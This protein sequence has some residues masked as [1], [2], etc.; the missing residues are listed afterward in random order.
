MRDFDKTH[1]V[2]LQQNNH[3]NYVDCLTMAALDILEVKTGDILNTYM[4]APNRETYELYQVQ[5]VGTML[6]SQ[7]YMSD[8]FVV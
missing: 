7:P 4:T 6:I 1:Q 8:H 2:E 3:N 5:S